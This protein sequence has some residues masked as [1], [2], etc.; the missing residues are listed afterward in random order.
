MTQA[1]L[2]HRLLLLGIPRG[3]ERDRAEVRNLALQVADW[4]SLLDV[5]ERLGAVALL[6]K[7]LAD[8][9][10]RRP[11]AVDEACRGALVRGTLRMALATRVL[12][13]A[14][15]ALGRAG[16]EPLVLKGV[17]LAHDLYEPPGLRPIGDIDLLVRRADR[18]AALGALRALGYALPARSLPLAFYFRHHFHVTL[19]RSGAEGLPIELHWQAQ[20]RF[21]LSRIPVEALYARRRIVPC[22][23]IEVPVPGREEAFLYLAQHFIRHLIAFGAAT[24]ADPAA[25]MLEPARRGRLTWLADLVLLARREPGL[26]WNRVDRLADE[27]GLAGESAGLRRHLASIEAAPPPAGMTEDTH[28]EATLRLI[29]RLARHFPTLA[30]ASGALQLRPILIARLWRFAF[31]GADWIRWRY[32]LE[33]GAGRT[34]VAIRGLGHAAG[35]AAAALRMGLGLPL[36]WLRVRLRPGSVTRSMPD[37]DGDVSGASS[38]CPRRIT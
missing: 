24:A 27:W 2:A 6:G 37:S 11:A 30:G 28:G 15:G 14:L 35:V 22:A 19:T 5:A 13:E 32:R 29:R 1:P 20:P 4:E 18:E 25:A 17:P 9:G 34:R 33:A 3:D 8:S 26:D 36:A 38:N 12:A 21:S 31:P 23:G 7:A 16:V 10:A